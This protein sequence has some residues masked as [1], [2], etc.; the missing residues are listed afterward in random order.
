MVKKCI[1][2]PTYFFSVSQVPI[3]YNH[4]IYIYTYNHL[5][6]LL[7]LYNEVATETGKETKFLENLSSLH[8]GHILIKL[9]GLFE[10]SK[11]VEVP[12]YK[13]TELL[14]SMMYDAQNESYPEDAAIYLEIL[15]CAAMMSMMQSSSI[16]L[17][18]DSSVGALPTPLK[19][20]NYIFLYIGN[21]I[22]PTDELI[23]FRGVGWNHQP[24]IINQ[25]L[26]SIN[27]Y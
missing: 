21:V 10:T 18:L 23:L 5:Q 1:Y 6:K 15:S 2:S 19:F 3:I 4:Y 22:I 17:A 16:S 13:V 14:L 25:W 11:R 12:F 8:S 20:Q 24:A 9:S 7:D 27:H 26:T